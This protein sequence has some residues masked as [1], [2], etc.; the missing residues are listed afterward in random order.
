MTTFGRNFFYFEMV[1]VRECV[2]MR[3]F[4][5]ICH[6]LFI[7]S[8]IRIFDKEFIFES[9]CSC[10]FTRQ[11]RPQEC[12]EFYSTF[13]WNVLSLWQI[14]REVHNIKKCWIVIFL[15][16]YF[17]YLLCL[18]ISPT[19]VWF[20]IHLYYHFTNSVKPLLQL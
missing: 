9:L 20:H 1:C 3:L 4:F 2:K 13:L 5:A 10:E 18:S 17:C 19:V 7:N 11:W 8:L 16:V 6:T 15:P 12:K 14:L